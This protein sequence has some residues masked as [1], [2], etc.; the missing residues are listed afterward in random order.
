MPLEGIDDRR[1]YG[2]VAAS[3]LLCTTP[4]MDRVAYTD[5]QMKMLN[6]IVAY[7]SLFHP[8]KTA[9]KHLRDDY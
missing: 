4:V 8:S 6:G 1:H 2:V 7:V 5:E 3:A 9:E